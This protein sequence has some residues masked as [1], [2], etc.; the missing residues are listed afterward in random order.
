MSALDEL[1]AGEP[2]PDFLAL[3]RRVIRAV[4]HGD[5]FPP[6]EDSNRWDGPAVMSCIADFFASA[7]T[8]RRLKDLSTCAD[9]QALKAKLHRTVRNFL[10]DKGRKTTVGRLVLRFNEVL[11]RT[12]GFDRRG[13]RWGR[14]GDP[15]LPGEVNREALIVAISD[16]EVVVPTAYATGD[17]KS[18]DLDA[19]SVVRI[20]DAMITAAGGPLTPAVLADVAAVR[21]GIRDLPLSLDATAFSQPPQPLEEVQDA[22]H[23][24]AFLA[25][26]VAKVLSRL[27]ERHLVTLGAPKASSVELGAIL[28]VSPSMANKIK[29]RAIAIMSDELTGEDGGEL[30]ANT[31]F[32]LARS[33]LESW[34]TDDDPT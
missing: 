27:D 15:S 34:M 29:N 17:R 16:I 13:P 28:G 24:D 5:G 22:V 12:D 6:P 7:Q 26:R 14:T 19:P 25:D 21:L 31:V 33:W 11:G 4:G 2:G 8:E 23:V 32:D 9:E 10:A 18:P 20:A 3:L 30:V 1:L